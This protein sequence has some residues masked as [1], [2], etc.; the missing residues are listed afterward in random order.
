M[1]DRLRSKI[2]APAWRFYLRLDEVTH[3]R[4]ADLVEKVLNIQAKSTR[5]R[6]QL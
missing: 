4:F 5:R 6:R 3:E 1:Q 2:S